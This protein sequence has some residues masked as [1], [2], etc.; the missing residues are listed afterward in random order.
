MVYMYTD[1]QL[2]LLPA[3]S[4]PKQ[5]DVDFIG[6]HVD[7]IGFHVDFIRF[8]VDFIGFYRFRLFTGVL[9]VKQCSASFQ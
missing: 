6:F 9:E 4:F 1:H 3:L 5:F 8:H 2:E 7:F